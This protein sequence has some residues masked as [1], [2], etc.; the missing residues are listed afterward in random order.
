M[1]MLPVKR[2][3]KTVTVKDL[4]LDFDSAMPDHAVE[5]DVLKMLDE[6]NALCRKH[7]NA[8]LPQFRLANEKLQL[9]VVPIPEYEED[10]DQ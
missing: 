1:S 4:V 10:S 3:N 6:I 8:S 7:L 9:E 5:K 2:K